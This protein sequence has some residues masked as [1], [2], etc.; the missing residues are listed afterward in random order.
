MKLR[1]WIIPA[2]LVAMLLAGFVSTQPVTADDDDHHY[3]RDYD[4]DDHGSWWG[5]DDD[6]DHRRGHAGFL[7]ENQ[8]YKDECGSCHMAFQPWLLPERSWVLIMDNT[9]DHYGEDLFLAPET[10][11]EI[12]K[13]VIANSAE[14]TSVRNEWAGPRGDVM[15]GLG[16]YTPKRITDV[17]YIREEHSEELSPDVFKRESIKSASNCQA[18]HRTA[19]RGDY[20]EDNIRVPR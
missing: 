1:L 5:G 4:D 13:Y 16:S 7:P 20:E 9:S 14:N 17:P 18:C 6:D 2:A 3:G 19:D 10:V 11:D 12:R 8:L 15:K